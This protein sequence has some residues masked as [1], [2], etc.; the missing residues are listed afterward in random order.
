MPR[1]RRSTRSAR[2]FAP[3]GRRCCRPPPPGCRSRTGRD[4][5]HRVRP[6]REGHWST[7]P[8]RRWARGSDS[9]NRL[10][11]SPRAGTPRADRPGPVLGSRRRPRE[12]C[13]VVARLQPAGP[14]WWRQRHASHDSR[15][16]PRAT[17]WTATRCVM[18]WRA[19]HRTLLWCRRARPKPW[20]VEDERW[21]V[22]EPLLPKVEH[23]A[24]HTGRK[25]HPGRLAFQGLQFGLHTA[26]AWE[27][28]PQELGV[29]SGRN[30][31]RRP[32]ATPPR[33]TGLGGDGVRCDRPG[34]VR[35]GGA[36]ARPRAPTPCSR[37]RI[38]PHPPSSR[39]DQPLPRPDVVR[40]DRTRPRRPAR[41]PRPGRCPRRLSPA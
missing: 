19:R 36:T 9:R 17:T 29:G 30:C 27:N 32:G 5:P 40:V 11:T 18:T 37:W 14:G 3:P 34:F 22:V 12:R 20:H 31:W 1:P 39:T 10:R 21:A 23:R 13:D 15:H 7:G 28:L 35:G 26:I 6:L 24:R 41:R 4:R 16:R 38:A 25:R 8:G 33:W 2:C